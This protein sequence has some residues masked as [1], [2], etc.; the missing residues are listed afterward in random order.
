[1]HKSHVRPISVPYPGGKRMN[2]FMAWLTD[3]SVLVLFV[4]WKQVKLKKILT[5]VNM[6]EFAVTIK[7]KTIAWKRSCMIIT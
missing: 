4:A 2:C 5:Q 3:E 1:M 6:I 7:T